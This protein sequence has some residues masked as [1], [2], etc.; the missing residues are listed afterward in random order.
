MAGRATLASEA[1]SAGGRRTRR[2]RITPE[3]EAELYEAVLDLLGEVGYEALT[4]G[5]VAT[6]THCSKATLYRQWTGKPE[7]V[8]MA[9][10]HDRAGN[11]ADIDTGTLR[12]D[13]HALAAQMG[14]S[15]MQK[16]SDLV[17][18]LLQAVHTHPEL[19]QAVREL[20][21]D[22]E[23]TGLDAL[24]RRAVERGELAAEDPAL[25][26]IPHILVGALITR[27]LLEDRP[28]DE[29]FFVGYIDAALLSVLGV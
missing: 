10:R 3:R 16:N 27:P 9:L 7:L 13:F 23:L 24:L 25:T 21:V 18:S 14:D 20:F 28:V 5:E 4:M 19:L 11:L 6:R 26:Y 2:S 22:P 29:A 1:E 17:R 8:A 12:G 15:R